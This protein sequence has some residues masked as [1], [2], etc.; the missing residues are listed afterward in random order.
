MT[1]TA[2]NH[3][4]RQR[5]VAHHEA[6]HAVAA[7]VLGLGVRDAW[8][9]PPPRHGGECNHI[10]EGGGAIKHLVYTMAGPVAEAR[11]RTMKPDR[12]GSDATDIGKLLLRFSPQDRAEAAA[13][14]RAMAQALTTKYW[15]AIRSVADALLESGKV[16]GET[17]AQLVEQHQ[18]R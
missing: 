12:W 4:E 2:I 14:A 11:Y 1:T 17:V 9:G 3:S 10:D 6:G 15:S 7:T 18:G 13:H 5:Q 8:I 16:T